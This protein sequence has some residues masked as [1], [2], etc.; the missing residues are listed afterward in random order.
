MFSAKDMRS[1]L[2]HKC[3]SAGSQAEW[4][5]QNNLDGAYVS[6]V[7]NG[8]IQPGGKMLAALGYRKIT[9]FVALQQSD[10]MQ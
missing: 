4:C 9:T 6:A 7:L 2:R 8:R 3:E 1:F 5:R 10:D